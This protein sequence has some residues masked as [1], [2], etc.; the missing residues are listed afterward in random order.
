MLSAI[1]GVTVQ[2]AAHMWVV[3]KGLWQIMVQVRRPVS[4]SASAQTA[5]HAAPRRRVVVTGTGVVTPLG[6]EVRSIFCH[7][8]F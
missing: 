8:P 6:H 2:P 5:Q 4:V 7:G 3:Y 1:C